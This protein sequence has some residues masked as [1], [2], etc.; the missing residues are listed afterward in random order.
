VD[1]GRR[2][3]QT[4]V[5]RVVP[6][7]TATSPQSANVLRSLANVNAVASGGPVQWRL[8]TE[9]N[10]GLLQVVS[11][12]EPPLPDWSSAHRHTHAPHLETL[13]HKERLLGYQTLSLFSGYLHHLH[14]LAMSPAEWRARPI[15]NS[16]SLLAN[17]ID[18]R[19]NQLTQH[20]QHLP[21]HR[22]PALAT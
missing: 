6:L 11:R 3:Q 13:G 9:R 18:S 19:F 12:L 22:G 17:V 15:P 8:T 4:P 7:T 2:S 21:Q 10:W 16:T 14:Q 20:D 5:V 1:D